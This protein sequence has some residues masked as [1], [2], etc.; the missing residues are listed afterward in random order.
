MCC[1]SSPKNPDP[2]KVEITWPVFP[3]PKD[4]VTLKDGVVT[5]PLSYWL[6]IANYA[7]DVEKVKNILKALDE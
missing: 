5:M 7:V 2:V 4:Q 1:Q 6:Q 3:D